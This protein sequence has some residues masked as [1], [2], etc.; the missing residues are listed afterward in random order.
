MPKKKLV[1]N[2]PPHLI[3]QAITY[4][5]ITDYGL[6]VNILRARITPQEWGSM[7]LELGDGNERLAEAVAFLTELGVGVEPLSKEV[8]WHE[9]RCIHC[10]AC[11]GP[12]PTVSFDQERCIACELCLPVCPYQ[13]VEIL[14]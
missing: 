14:F 7:V 10:T 2:F 12:C 8:R 4:R 13:A 11:T 1:L 5:L 6:V 3:G 9:E